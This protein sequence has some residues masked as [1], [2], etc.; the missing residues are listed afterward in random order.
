MIRGRE[1]AEMGLASKALP[2]EEVLPATVQLAREFLKAAPLSVA[3]S[4]RLLWEGLTS[5]VND[6]FKREMAIFEWIC[7]QPD[8]A[9]GIAS[10]LE[11]R[12]PEWSMSADSDVPGLLDG[13]RGDWGENLLV[14]K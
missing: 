8:A 6:M 14:K 5:S 7:H 2:A 1:L 13:G 10:F 11:K 3:V 4:K 12:D 9:E